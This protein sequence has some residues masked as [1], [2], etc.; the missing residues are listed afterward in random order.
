[1]SQILLKETS[2]FNEAIQSTK[3]FAN[4][5]RFLNWPKLSDVIFLMQET[6]SSGTA[7]VGYQIL[8]GKN[9]IK[10]IWGEGN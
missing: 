4:K 9:S 2:I 3:N 8:S 5:I 1:M 7:Y 10:P 6:K